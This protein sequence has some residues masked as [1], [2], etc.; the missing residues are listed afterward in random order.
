[1]LLLLP[2]SVVEA[3]KLGS[4][5]TDIKAEIEDRGRQKMHPNVVFEEDFISSSKVSL[6]SVPSDDF[7]L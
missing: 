4:C 2:D 1:L 3:S 5:T 7:F 6:L